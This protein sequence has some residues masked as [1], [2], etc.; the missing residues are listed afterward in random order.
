MT[1]YEKIKQMPLCEMR[2]FILHQIRSDCNGYYD[3]A[4]EEEGYTSCRDCVELMRE[5]KK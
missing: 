5:V 2:D 1:F 4:C 3:E